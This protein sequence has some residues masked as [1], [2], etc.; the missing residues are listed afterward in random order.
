M[1]KTFLLTFVMELRVF[2]TMELFSGLKMGHNVCVDLKLEL[3]NTLLL[4][5]VS[6]KALPIQ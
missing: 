2:S 1:T 5:R 3:D 6:V 4:Q